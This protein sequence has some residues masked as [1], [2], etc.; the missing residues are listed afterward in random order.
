MSLPLHIRSAISSVA[1][2]LLEIRWD[3]IIHLADD[4]G[5]AA[6]ERWASSASSDRAALAS[7]RNRVWVAESEAIVVGWIEVEEAKVK[8]LYV[9]SS[10]SRSGVG[11]SLMAYAECAI[12]LQGAVTVHLDA[13]PNAVSFYARLGYEVA[14]NPKPDTSVPMVK[15]FGN[16]A[17]HYDARGAQLI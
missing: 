9:D 1:Q 11:S 5:Y 16:D 10:F 13:S 6:V 3:A 2:R 14:G 7:E 12:Q 4:F 8:G 17:S 15:C